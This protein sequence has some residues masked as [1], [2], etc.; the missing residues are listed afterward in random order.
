MLHWN[1][2][3]TDPFQVYVLSVYVQGLEWAIHVLSPTQPTII[4]IFH[5]SG[6]FRLIFFGVKRSTT[7]RWLIANCQTIGIAQPLLTGR[8]HARKHIHAHIHTHTHRQTHTKI[9]TRT[10]THAHTL[11]HTHTYTLT[12]SHIHLHTY[13]HTH[14]HT[15]IHT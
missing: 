12:H 8:T 13:T 14:T 15:H 6:L 1:H 4:L 10:H 7:D 11:T 5:Q 9:R 2:I 3:L